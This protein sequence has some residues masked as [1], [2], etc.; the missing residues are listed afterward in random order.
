MKTPEQLKEVVDSGE[1]L[2]EYQY[3]YLKDV[4]KDGKKV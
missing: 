1:S 4:M 3:N 2:S